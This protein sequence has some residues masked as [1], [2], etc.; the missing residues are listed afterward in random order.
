MCTF[1]TRSSSV[2][3]L[4]RPSACSSLQIT[5][6]CFRYASPRL[7]SGISFLLHSINLLF[8]VRLPPSLP[9]VVCITF[10]QSLSSLSLSVILQLFYSS[11]KSSSAPQIFSSI[12]LWFPLDCFHGIGL[13]LDLLCVVFIW[14]YFIFYFMAYV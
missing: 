1:R 9:H 2:V 10:S 11:L 14:F 7:T 3:T 4:A 8:P 6:R 13:G 5:N 12:D